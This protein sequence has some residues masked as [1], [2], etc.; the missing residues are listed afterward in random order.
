MR[1]SE[2]SVDIERLRAWIGREEEASDILTPRLVASLRATLD[3]AHH[4]PRRSEVVPVM[5]HWCLTPS[6][7]AQSGLGPDGHPARGGFLPP[8]ALPRRMWASSDV[9]FLAPVETG[10]TV[11]R[12]SR[13]HD[14]EIKEGR[15]G[16]LVFVSVDH[17]YLTAHGP[18]IRDRQ[19]IV[20]RPAETTPATP[21]P[22]PSVAQ[23][24]TGEERLLLF[25]DPPLLLR[26][27][28]LTFNTHRIHYD[29]PYAMAQE[30]YPGLVVHG[31]LQ[32]SLLAEFAA[33]LHDGTAPRRFS[34][35][36]LAPLFDGQKFSLCARID[37]QTCDLRIFDRAN[38]IT[39]Q[40]KAEW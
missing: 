9:E 35:R 17:L 3:C 16:A 20:Y 6:I 5:V 13:I 22:S 28:A 32:A 2:T 30:N 37:G 12:R 38:R 4:F 29:R 23:Q 33:E 26:Y 25:A 40:A 21:L 7:A 34:F 18:A 36:G 27:S 11:K 31:P 15:S 8:V 19:M 10:A 24:E 39:M 14:M 1:S